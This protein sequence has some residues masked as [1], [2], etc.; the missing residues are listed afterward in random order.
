VF[1]ARLPMP[2]G[3]DVVALGIKAAAARLHG[4]LDALR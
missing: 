2:A 1:G 3:D 4:A